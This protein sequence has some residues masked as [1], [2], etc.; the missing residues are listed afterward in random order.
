MF[1]WFPIAALLNPLIFHGVWRLDGPCLMVKH[2]WSISS[3]LRK[4]LHE[5]VMKIWSCW[6]IKSSWLM[7]RFLW[8]ML[9]KNKIQWV[10]YGY[11]NNQSSWFFTPPFLGHAHWG[12][13]LRESRRSPGRDCVAANHPKTGKNR[14]HTRIHGGFHKW[15]TPKNAGWFIMRK[16]Y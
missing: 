13:S 12:A 9:G 6:T 1:C 15:G 11:I 2:G 4:M 16:P 7:K 10:K 3:W 8:K 5:M 14:S